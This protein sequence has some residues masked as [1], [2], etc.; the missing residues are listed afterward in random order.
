[1]TQMGCGRAITTT[2]SAGLLLGVDSDGGWLDRAFRSMQRHGIFLKKKPNKQNWPRAFDG[3][4]SG[5][6][7]TIW[8]AA[9]QAHAKGSRNT[10]A[11]ALLEFGVALRFE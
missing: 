6:K 3:K 1:M 4:E 11:D 2:A 8:G 10:T 7:N 9:V 5:Q